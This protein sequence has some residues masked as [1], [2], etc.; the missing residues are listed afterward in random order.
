M[1]DEIRKLY[2]YAGDSIHCVDNKDKG[3]LE[4]IA[5]N[6]SRI[7]SFEKPD[8][9]VQIEDKVLA[10]EHFEFDASSCGKKG[11]LDKRKLAERNRDFDKVII[12]SDTA[13]E[14]LIVTSSV[15]CLYSPDYYLDNFTSVFNNHLNKIETYN[16]HII[17]EKIVKSIDDIIMCFFIIDTTPL[18]CYYMD[19]GPKSFVAF[20]VKEC[21]DL[22]TKAKEIDCFFFGLFDGQSNSLEFIR[23]SPNIVQLIKG[24]RVLDFNH[25]EFFTFNPQETRFF[26]N[27]TV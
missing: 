5:A 3:L 17:N 27:E 2:E 16:K 19:D 15:D 23:N 9:I 1:N 13:E 7:K 8:M 25:D 11:S 26:I 6:W 14:P 12:E 24:I 4:K 22:I 10:I 21:L 18:G 20:Q